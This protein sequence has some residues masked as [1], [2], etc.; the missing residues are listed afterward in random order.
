MRKL[1]VTT[2]VMV[3]LSIAMPWTV[4]A[5]P[6]TPQFTSFGALPDATFGGSGIPN[7]DVAI[8]TTIDAILGL[9][10]HGR[11]TNP[12]PTNDGAG[13]FFAQ[14]GNDSAHGQPGYTTDNWGWYAKIM[15]PGTLTMYYD[16]DPVMTDDGSWQVVFSQLVGPGV[17]QNSWNPGMGFL[18]EATN[19]NLA[20][21]SSIRMMFT[22]SN[23]SRA[24]ISNVSINV[25]R[26]DRSVPEPLM[27]SMLG[28]GILGIGV[29]RRLQAAQ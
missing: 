1:F 15:S 29:R 9:T 8:T 5:A 7:T 3:M 4:Q 6:I 12:N 10:D 27:I 25:S 2:L 21:M 22:P 16:T 11:F 24:S 26:G 19:P 14:V 13:N 20:N 28:I 23:G 17:Y 18:P